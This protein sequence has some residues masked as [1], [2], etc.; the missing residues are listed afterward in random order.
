MIREDRIKSFSN[1]LLRI[2]K[3]KS[4]S[5]CRITHKSKHTFISKLCKSRKINRISNNRSIVH[6]KV[7]AANMYKRI[8]Y[9]PVTGEFIPGGWLY[10]TN[11]AVP[12]SVNFGANFNITK[13]YRYDEQTSK[14]IN[15]NNICATVNASGNIRLTP[16]MNINM[17]TGYDFVAKAITTTQFSATYDLHCFNISVSWVPTGKWKSYSFRIAANASALT[18][19]LRFKKSDSYWDN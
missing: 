9:H 7:S 13:G 14:L 16:K 5:I 18:D 12:W 1:S 19:L 10:Y 11:P 4:F 8:Y 3:S 15:K 17:S 2:S 6:L